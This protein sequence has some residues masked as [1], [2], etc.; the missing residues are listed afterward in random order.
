MEAIHGLPLD[1]LRLLFEFS[2]ST[3][4]ESAKVLSL[5]S[6]EVQ[7]WTDPHLFQIV[8]KFGT[9]S[10]GISETS[11]LG[12]MC[13]PDAS[14]RIILARN[15]V[16]S[17]VWDKSVP[18]GSYTEQALKLFPNLT[19]LC[20]WQNIFPANRK[21][22]LKQ[23]FETTQSYPSL[24]RVATCLYSQ[25]SVPP[26]AFS[27][28]FW[29]TIT[30]LQVRSVIQISFMH[31][32]FQL[33]LFIPM[34]SL[35]HLAISR[36]ADVVE[37]DTNLALSRVRG[38]FPPSLTLCLLDLMPYGSVSLRHWFEDMTEACLKIDERIVM[39]WPDPRGDIDEMA[40]VRSNDPFQDW[41]RVQDG[42][43]TFWEMGEAVLK[44]RRERLQ[45]V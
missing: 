34:T 30:H 28:P 17:L 5:V 3:N 27:S 41:C 16:R 42:A 21:D 12:Q 7:S 39:W 18:K 22:P 36:F 9:N 2:A 4:I 1:I 15:Y 37:L 20:L 33:P 8:R 25:L 19:Q 23:D 11:L 6:K 24:R 35:T 43:Q 26:N 44:R 31:S 14:P 38:T 45:A 10:S 13:I 40:V 29:M 32:A